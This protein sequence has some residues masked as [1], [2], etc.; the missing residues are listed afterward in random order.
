MVDHHDKLVV[1]TTDGQD[2]TFEVNFSED[3]AV[4]DCKMFRITLGEGEKTVT[5]AR[6]DLLNIL[7]ACG[8]P[9]TQKKLLPIKVTNVKKLHRKLYFTFKAKKDYRAGEVIETVA[10]W[11]DEVPTETEMFSGNF[12]GRKPKII[13]PNL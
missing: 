5:I 2:V 6:N 10:D 3:P 4:Q 1:K 13:N 12:S 7:L 9:G 11:I 8:D